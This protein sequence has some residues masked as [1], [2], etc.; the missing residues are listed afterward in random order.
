MIAVSACTDRNLEAVESIIAAPAY[1]DSRAPVKR[2]KFLAVFCE[3][4]LAPRSGVVVVFPA[5]LNIYRDAHQ[6][7]PPICPLVQRFP[8]E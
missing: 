3:A 6:R 8:S 2:R 1:N 5:A 7:P 4:L